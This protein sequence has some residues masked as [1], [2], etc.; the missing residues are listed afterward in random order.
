[1]AEVRGNGRYRL[2]AGEDDVRLFNLAGLA[3]LYY[4]DEASARQIITGGNVL[5]ARL[6]NRSIESEPAAISAMPNSSF[7]LQAGARLRGPEPALSRSWDC[8][9]ESESFPPGRHSLEEFNGRFGLRLRRLDNA[10]SYGAVN[11]SYS[12]GGEGLDVREYDS[13]KI[14]ATFFLNYQSLSQCGTLSSECPLMLRLDYEDSLRVDRY[15]I[16]GFYYDKE[17]ESEF[18]T[19]CST[20][21][22]DHVVANKRVWYT[23]ESENLLT[24]INNVHHPARLES[25]QFYASGH[26][27]DTVVGEIILLLD[28]SADAYNGGQADD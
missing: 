21:L 22:Q 17:V 18:D 7:S 13:I 23:F 26:Q 11:C 9:S 4:A 3:S 28:K 1:M 12:F 24:L 5:V 10:T 16:R 8:A 19:R 27:F 14:A 20:C 25:F 2:S 6:S 15:W